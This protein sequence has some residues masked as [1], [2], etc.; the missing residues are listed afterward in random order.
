M[1]REPQV[2]VGTRPVGGE[3][4]EAPGE[5]THFQVHVDAPEG[6]HTIERVVMEF[7]QPGVNHHHGGSNGPFNGLVE[8][9]DD[10]THG[11]PVAGDG[12]YHYM[13]PQDR[14]GCGARNAPN[15]EYQYRF[16]CE[17]A[18]GTRSN[19][20]SVTVTRRIR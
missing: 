14:I 7:T 3:L 4:T 12:I 17:D 9:Y 2:L 8:C 20:V 10:G 15:G 13:D 16:W 19:T 5:P 18:F 1:V 6:L 11:D